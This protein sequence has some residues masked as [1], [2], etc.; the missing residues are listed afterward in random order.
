MQRIGGEIVERENEVRS[1][2]LESELE[3]LQGQVI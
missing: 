2:W 1:E 3:A